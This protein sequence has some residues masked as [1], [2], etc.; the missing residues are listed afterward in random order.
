M[1]VGRQKRVQRLLSFY[2]NN[3]GF[4]KPFKVVADGTFC[5]A[6]LENKINLREQLH[7]YLNEEVLLLTTACVLRELHLLGSD[8]YG[9]L[10][11]ASQF[12]VEKCVHKGV[13]STED[14]FLSLAKKKKCFFGTQDRQLTEQ[15]REVPGRP[16]LFI[17]YSTVLLEKPSAR[18]Y[19]A[20]E[21]DIGKKIHAVGGQKE[22]V[23]KLKRKIFGEEPAAP[24]K[25]QRRIKG[26][27]PL[28]CK[29]KKKKTTSSDGTSGKK[30][31]RQRIR[32]KK[33]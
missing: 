29:P 11:I 30:N 15:L 23:V 7:K 2:R 21:T 1:R 9:A 20:A 4:A 33:N 17:K 18:S 16:I 26:P 28:S 10:H 13:A 14:C 5:L 22:S 31:K 25:K 27:N 12:V 3:F 24:T 32:I 8:F 19:E 6:A